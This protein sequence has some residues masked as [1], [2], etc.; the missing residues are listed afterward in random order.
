M[1][2]C[3]TYW[4]RSSD[5]IVTPKS[6]EPNKKAKQYHQL[7]SL[8]EK[9]NRKG[10]RKSRGPIEPHACASRIAHAVKQWIVI[11]FM[12]GLIS[13]SLKTCIMRETGFF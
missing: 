13:M 10:T 11:W 5:S 2:V 4:E 7:D 8:K 3:L 6:I 12:L 9:K 1:I